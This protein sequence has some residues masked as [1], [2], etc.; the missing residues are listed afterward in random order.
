MA[1]P[2]PTPAPG[3]VRI[4]AAAAVDAALLVAL[5]AG[6]AVLATAWLLVRSESGRLDVGATDAAVAVSVIAAAAPAWVAWTLLATRRRLPTPG[7]GLARIRPVPAGGAP[8]GALYVRAAAAPL[9]LP[10]WLWAAATPLVA[11][12][13]PWLALP[14]LV[15]ATGVAAAA[16][17]SLGLLLVRPRA[18]LLHDRLARTSLVPVEP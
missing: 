18:R 8:R 15:G 3:R 2:T 9:S 5:H 14:P 4:V 13:P 7:Q 16:L 10:G 6:A 1:T 11:G 12:L 17:G